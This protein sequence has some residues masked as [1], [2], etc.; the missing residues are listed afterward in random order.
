MRSP[1]F[2]SARVGQAVFCLALIA[3]A[4][5]AAPPAAEPPPLMP[6]VAAPPQP[7]EEPPVTAA[8]PP[9]PAPKYA[10]HVASYKN[11]A[12]AEAAWPSY[13]QRFPVVKDQPR[14]YVEIDL[15]PQRGK[16]VRLLLGSF[17]EQTDVTHFCHSLRDAGL[18]CAPH[19]IPEQS[20][21][22]TNS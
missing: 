1:K 19:S 11:Q 12:E 16:V 3:V 14:R 6:T 4:G 17:H 9:P 13:A 10:G 15:G 8:P 20:V 21:A 2:H 22:E 7:P 5:C 18:Y